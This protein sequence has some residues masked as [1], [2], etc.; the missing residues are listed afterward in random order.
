MEKPKK[1]LLIID[2]DETLRSSL[3]V[4]FKTKDYQV[5]EA[6]N[7]KAGL[8]AI[9]SEQPNAVL[10]DIMM[11]EMTGIELIKAVSES[12]PDML[13]RIT[14]MTNSSSMNYLSEA[15]DL[16]VLKYVLKGDMSLEQIFKIVDAYAGK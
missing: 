14:L 3:A 5:T 9:K 2:D 11:P 6:V 16:G 10:L 15:V 4:F 8:D 13:D 7:G 12:N 1:T